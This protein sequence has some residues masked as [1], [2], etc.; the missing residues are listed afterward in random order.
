MKKAKWRE[1]IGIRFAC[2]ETTDLKQ[3]IIK[4]D[5]SVAFY[6][7]TVKPKVI[8]LNMFRFSCLKLKGKNK[9]AK[10]WEWLWFDFGHTEAQ[11]KNSSA[12]I[13]DHCNQ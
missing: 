1:N 9:N 6:S 3:I 13:G 4:L 5:N 7:H 2:R 8:V 12:L 10:M 11:T